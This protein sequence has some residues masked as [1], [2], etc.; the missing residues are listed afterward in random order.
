MA[1]SSHVVPFAGPPLPGNASSSPRN[2]R[3]RPHSTLPVTR[4]PT[5]VGTVHLLPDKHAVAC[6]F[7]AVIPELSD[8]HATPDLTVYPCGR[9][10]LDSV[11]LVPQIVPYLEEQLLQALLPHLEALQDMDTPSEF[12][13]VRSRALRIRVGSGDVM[14]RDEDGYLAAYWST[15]ELEVNW[16]IFPGQSTFNT[17][18]CMGTEA[19]K[20]ALSAF[21][22]ALL[23]ADQADTNVPCRVMLQ[24]L[25][26][27][28]HDLDVANEVHRQHWADYTS[29]HVREALSV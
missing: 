23:L 16:A 29:K 6:G 2:M 12:L 1:S 5:P 19:D 18:H 26:Q 17:A 10:E 4:I 14:I 15:D 21:N 3:T 27:H 25:R 9:V 8:H 11:F 7:V 13:H 20:E 24:A 28:T 22:T